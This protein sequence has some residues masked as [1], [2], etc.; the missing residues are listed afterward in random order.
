MDDVIIFGEGIERVGVRPITPN[1]YWITHCLGDCANEYYA[2][3]FAALPEAEQYDYHKNVDYPFSSFLIVDEKTL[4][5]DTQAPTQR[6]A[7]LQ[8]LEH[9]LG[10]R[11][12]DYVWISHIEIPHAGNAPAILERYPNA[13][14]VTTKGGDH[15]YP[16][17]GLDNAI[18]VEQGDVIELGEHSLEMIDAVFVDHGFSQWAIERKTGMFIS[19]DWGHNLHDAARGQCYMFLDE[20]MSDT[21]YN[22]EVYLNDVKVNYWYQFPW[23]AFTDAD[24]IAAAVDGI[25]QRHDVKI[26]APSHGNIIRKDIDQYVPLLREAMRQA[27]AIPYKFD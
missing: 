20:M 12:L 3:Y 23:L 1:I 11:E 19:I 6:E 18:Q 14:I 21:D 16:L 10:E 26:F 27:V 25:F 5:V 15:Y 8:A 22:K 13:K 17:H 2:D 4:L 9:I 24:E 7:T